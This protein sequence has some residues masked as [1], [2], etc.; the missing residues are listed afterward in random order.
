MGAEAAVKQASAWVRSAGWLA[1]K[2]IE[3]SL[4]QLT[5][6]QQEGATE[7]V[8]KL[9]TR[10]ERC[11]LFVRFDTQLDSIRAAQN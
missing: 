3:M 7:L 10:C 1:S 9:L 4:P 8:Q 11:V 5:H 2:G 6:V